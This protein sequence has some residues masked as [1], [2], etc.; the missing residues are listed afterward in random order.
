MRRSRTVGGLAAVALLALAVRALAWESVLLPD[1][2]VLF[3]LGDAWYH[4]RRAF[5][6][7]VHFPFVLL[8]DPLLNHPQ[9]AAVPWP[10]LYDFA[11][12]AVA[13]FFG[14]T[15]PS[16][17]RAV[18]W[19]PPACGVLSALATFAA[20]R[21]LAGSTLA[22]GAA[23]LLALIPVH[24]EYS[25][26]GNIDHH[27]AASFLG[28]TLLALVLHVSRRD[29]RGLRL[30]SLSLGLALVRAV[31]ILTWTGGV[32]YVGLGDASLA[33]VA[34]LEGR[35]DL[36]AAQG[37]SAA[38]SALLLAPEAVVS[39]T[40]FGG[41]YS[42]V[43]LSRL[44]PLALLALALVTLA[45]AGAERLRPAA[46]A[47]GRV[48][49]AAALA[50]GVLA[51]AARPIGLGQEL[52]GAGEFL[53]K[54][55]DWGGRNV[56][57]FPIF[58]GR[59][60]VHAI[61]RYG[62]LAYA[63]PLAP[64][65]ALAAAR[66]RRR[67]E[68]ALIL[69]GFSAVLGALAIFQMRY[70]NEFA[71]G[72][73]VAFALGLSFLG[74]LAARHLRLSDRWGAALA[75]ALAALLIAPPV[76]GRDLP[77]AVASLRA[78]GARSA[79][80][81][82]AALDSPVGS[83]YRFAEEIRRVTPDTTGFL[84]VGQPVEYGILV[85]PNVGHLIHYVAR[86]ATPADNFGPY[87]GKANFEAVRRFFRLGLE[88]DAVAEA[89]RL[90]VRYVLTM[91]YDVPIPNSLLER[92]QREDGLKRDQLPRWSHFRLVTEG[93]RGGRSLREGF[94]L[95]LD[96]HAVPYKLFEVVEGAVLEAHAA[97]GTPVAASA[98]IRTPIGRTFVYE[99][100]GSAGPDGVARLRVPYPTT[101]DA[102][103]RPVAPWRVRVGDS[104]VAVAVPEQAVEN[105]EV[106]VVPRSGPAALAGG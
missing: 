38:A 42:A 13:R 29:A 12:A 73:A 28:A 103:A 23:T 81:E 76:L 10:P 90:R 49:R 65:A 3:D 33:L 45:V 95:P 59:L 79:R 75:A 9:G 41:A 63:I 66:E 68:P 6:T 88:D 51:L 22:L 36:L 19:V 55:D 53:A 106:V 62:F 35:S 40:S 99:A 70:G 24:V 20:A 48:L 64:L 93:P 98:T 71:P 77:E 14:E 37:L 74:R 21:A 27:A 82:D 86:R 5:F 54:Q 57:Q 87:A 91:D 69:A 31:L 16:F 56:E 104:A 60:G 15:Q 89:R 94:G 11:L 8:W 50:A 32:I 1:G 47:L 39:G 43:E 2:R 102:P 97:P 78:L 7:F 34:L 17:E 105:G 44:Q 46:S 58:T 26:V 84:Q 101:T 72:G 30:A 61:A 96:P 80:G 52:S 4:A 85:H 83:L 92:L 67:R 100:E 18:A 25:H